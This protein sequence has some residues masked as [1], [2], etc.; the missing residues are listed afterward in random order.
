M[1]FKEQFTNLQEV[2]NCGH[3]DPCYTEHMDKAWA[4]ETVRLK[5]FSQG[6]IQSVYHR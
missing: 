3:F 2:H 4:L 1:L 5:I 6:W